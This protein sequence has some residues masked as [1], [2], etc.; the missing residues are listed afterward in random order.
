MHDGTWALKVFSKETLI[1]SWYRAEKGWIWSVENLN[2]RY[3]SIEAKSIESKHFSALFIFSI[4]WYNSSTCLLNLFRRSRDQK[5]PSKLI[6]QWIIG[7]PLSQTVA[8]FIANAKTIEG[9]RT[10]SSVYFFW[11]G[12]TSLS[13]SLGVQKLRNLLY[14]VDFSDTNSEHNTEGLFIGGLRQTIGV[15]KLKVFI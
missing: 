15:L 9:H 3:S 13:F 12:C 7:Q 4:Y 11:D 6:K 2:R 14:F 1:A 8:E 5:F 10:L